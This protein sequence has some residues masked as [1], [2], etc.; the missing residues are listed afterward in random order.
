MVFCS[1]MFG[2]RISMMNLCGVFFFFGGV[3]KRT[4]KLQDTS[5]HT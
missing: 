4:D 1:N 2:W 5:S 3:S